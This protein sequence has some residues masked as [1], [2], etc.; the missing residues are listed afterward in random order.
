MTDRTAN[1]HFCKKKRTKPRKT[2]AFDDLRPSLKRCSP[3][4]KSLLSESSFLI[5]FPDFVKKKHHVTHDII[6]KKLQSK[7]QRKRFAGFVM[8]QR[9]I[10]ITTGFTMTFP[11]GNRVSEFLSHVTVVSFNCFNNRNP[12]CPSLPHLYG[13]VFQGFS[14][15]ISSLLL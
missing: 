14:P 11:P 2:L 1:L 7:Y 10:K 9:L 5:P 13:V 15:L 6:K 3:S 4:L 8:S 12:S